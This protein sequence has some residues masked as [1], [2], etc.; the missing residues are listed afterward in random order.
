MARTSLVVERSARSRFFHNARQLGGVLWAITASLMMAASARA[1]EP[2]TRKAEQAVSSRDE[3]PLSADERGML[4]ARFEQQ[5]ERLTKEI[6]AAPKSVSGYSRRGDAFFFAG[7][8]DAAVADY[9]TMVSLDPSLKTSHWRRGIA[10]FYAGQYK[11]AAHQFEIYHSFDDV[12]RENGIWRFL[13]QTKAVGIE[14]ARKG[15]LKYKKD[16]REPFPDVY[17]LFAGDRTPDEVMAAI[18]RAEIEDDERQKRM[19]YAH[20]Y[21]GLSESNAGRTDSARTHLREAVANPWGRSAGGGPGW[22]WHVARIHYER[23]AAMRERA[24]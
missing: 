7:Q 6:A 13:S 21:I 12:D 2:P 19:F 3:H 22:M 9:N 20:L 17:R 24:Q 5:I 4:K 1:D 14:T 23:L 15:L 10:W 18:E 16:D 11:D 8:F